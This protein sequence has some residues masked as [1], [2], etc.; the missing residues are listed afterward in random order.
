MTVKEGMAQ[1]IKEYLVKW[2]QPL[3]FSP[4]VLP[5]SPLVAKILSKLSDSGVGP[6]GIP[7]RLGL[8]LVR[9]G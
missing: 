1:E 6:D 2:T 8:L 4:C 7:I 3:D 5:D 9:M